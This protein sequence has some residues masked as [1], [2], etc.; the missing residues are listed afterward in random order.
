MTGS[1]IMAAF[2]G[3]EVPADVAAQLAHDP[4]AGFTLFRHHNVADPAQVRRLTDALRAA[5]PAASRPLLIAA[6]QEGGQ[7]IAMGEHTTDFAGPMAIGATG[8]EDLA[9][10]VALATGR[11]LRA[12]GVNV[13]YAPVCD[14]AT[15]PAHPVLGIRSFGEDAA[16]VSGLVAATV[17]GLQRAGV[18]ATAKHFPGAG[19]LMEDTHY[20]L[21]AVPLDREQ[22]LARELMP[23]GAAIA[24][25][26]QVVM[27]GHFALPALT[28]EAD[29]P[30]TLARPVMTRLLREDLRF[31]G[32]SITDALDMQALGQGGAQIVDAICALGA[33]VDLLLATPDPAK[34]ERLA[35]GLSQAVRRGLLDVAAVRRSAERLG[36]LRRWLAGFEQPPLEVVGS[37]EHRTLAREL[38]ERSI[39]LV[40]D[41]AELLPLRPPPD[42]RICVVMPRPADLTPADTSSYVAPELA[43]A[44]RRRHPRTEELLTEQEPS[45]AE[46]AATAERVA[47]CDILVI[48]TISA[49]LQPAQAELVRRLIALGRPSV[50]IALRTP[51]DLTAYPESRTHVCSYG[52]LP[53]TVEAVAGTLFGELPFRGRLPVT[54]GDLYPRGHGLSQ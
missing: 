31:D 47:G 11:E 48:G 10:R 14:L 51:W 46:I 3:R 34:L 29:L 32:V 18:A 45:A 25:G 26:A 21:A 33:G 27:S 17:R 28:G 2:A 40:R 23:F 1:S 4:V 52:I 30:A 42:A 15:N 7:L 49:S 24:A 16:S 9:E 36:A 13:D 39:T 50:T 35:G 20:E 44:I 8:D 54:L 41:E 5:A 53:P 37:T 12:L 43:N 19:D 22:L 38:A 6:D